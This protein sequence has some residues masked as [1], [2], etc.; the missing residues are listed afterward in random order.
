MLTSTVTSTSQAL[1]RLGRA[2]L[3]TPLIFWAN[4]YVQLTEEGTQTLGRLSGDPSQSVAQTELELLILFL[5]PFGFFYSFICLLG[6]RIN[7]G[8]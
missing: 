8:R 3:Y 7:Q 4:K 6:Q 5:F 1:S 2:S